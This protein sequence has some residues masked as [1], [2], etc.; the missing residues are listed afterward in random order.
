VSDA[1]QGTAQWFAD[2]AGYA[3]ASNF[4][5]ILAKG[6]GNEE[7]TTRRNYRIRLALERVLGRP[8]ESG[9]KSK[10]MDR[11]T[12][13]EPFGRMAFEER[14]RI[15]VHEAGFI[16]H[17]WLKAGASPDG[18]IGDDEGFEAKCPEPAAHLR[19]LELVNTAPVEYQPQVQGNLWITGRKVWNFISY[20]EDFPEGLQLHIVR[21]VRDEAYIARLEAEVSKFL[22]EVSV[23]ECELREM[24]DRRLVALQL[25]AA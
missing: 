13:Q 18:L 11:G 23:L 6:K 17:K 16:R 19:Y 20:N 8:M 10:A 4:D 14:T 9:F 24:N 7:A 15:L 1:I 21:V 2:R 5:A 22:A 3:S 25:A 12:E